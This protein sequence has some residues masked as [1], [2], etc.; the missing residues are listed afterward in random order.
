MIITLIG[1]F[2]KPLSYIVP[3]KSKTWIFGADCGNMY[4]EGSKYLLEYML[5]N[6]PDYQCSFITSN[7][8]VKEDL[9]TKGIPCEMNFSLK[10]IYKILRAEVVI[11][12]QVP[13]DIKLVY[14]KPHRYFYYCQHQ[15]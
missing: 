2:T 1:L 3:I 15:H 6:H 8:T 13:A 4:R 9:N 12:A 14:K 5:K 7:P 10:G 11:T